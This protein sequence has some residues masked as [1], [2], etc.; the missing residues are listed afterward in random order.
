MGQTFLQDSQ[1]AN[2][3]WE[4]P[5]KT[6][7]GSHL[8]P[9]RMAPQE[10]STAG[11]GAGRLGTCK[12]GGNVKR[13]SRCGDST[14]DPQKTAQN[15]HTTQQP[16]IREQTPAWESRLHP[17]PWRQCSRQRR[18]GGSRCPPRDG[19]PSTRPSPRQGDVPQPR[20]G[21]SCGLCLTQ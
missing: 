14:E 11:E 21:G 2:K 16:H 9:R 1:M 12:A 15:C 17:R 18:R 20:R 3:P 7:P 8:T 19:W 13:C 5:V 6:A 4:R 10:H